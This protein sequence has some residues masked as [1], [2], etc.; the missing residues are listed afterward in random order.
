M[1]SVSKLNDEVYLGLGANLGNPRQTFD[2]ALALIRGF[3]EVLSVSKLYKSEPF[4]Y[5]EQ[6]AFV[7]AAVRIAT[8]LEPMELLKKLQQ[9][10]GTLGKEVIR[11]N[12][13]RIIDIDLLLYQK[14]QIRNENLLVPHP[15]ILNRDF[16]LLPLS[17]LNPEINHP[18]WKGKTL[19]S[20]LG[21]LQ[22]R[23]VREEPEEWML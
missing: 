6:P 2:L 23:F 7:N 18:L 1:K 14:E 21:G 3:A 22:K 13:P 20:A 12:G 16:V 19:K 15:E 4:G 9:V 8:S 10:E 11:E 5:S 17:D